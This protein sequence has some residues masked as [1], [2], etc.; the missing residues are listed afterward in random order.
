MRRFLMLATASVVTCCYS[1]TPIGAGVFGNNCNL[2]DT[3]GPNVNAGGHLDEFWW[4]PT[5]GNTNLIAESRVQVVRYGGIQV[6]RDFQLDGSPTNSSSN[7]SKSVA[8][9]VRKVKI[10]RADGIEPMLTLPL[11]TTGVFT[12]FD[13]VAN[14]IWPL[15]RE[16][17]SALVAASVLPVRYWVYSN[18]P[19]DGGGLHGYDGV[20]AAKMIHRFTK[21]FHD[22][23]VAHWNSTWGA[24]KF[25]GPELYAY[26]NYP[27][28]TNKVDSL[29][30]QLT[31]F[32][33]PFNNNSN[34]AIYSILPYVDI[35]SFHIYPTN[36]QSM[37]TA[38]DP[39]GNFMQGTRSNVVNYLR[40]GGVFQN[41][42]PVSSLETNLTQ[43]NSRLATYNSANNKSIKAAITEA[44]LCHIH[45]I[46]G[47]SGVAEA[48]DTSVTG[49][50]AN[51]FIGGQWWAELMAVCMDKNTDLNFWS[52]L[53]GTSGSNPPYKN[54]IGFLYGN[55][56]V[57]GAK[58]PSF[59]HFKML[60]DNF[61]GTFW[62]GTYNHNSVSPSPTY[63][64]NGIKVFAAAQPAG[65]KVI[66][67]NHNASDYSYRVNLDTAGSTPGRVT[68]NLPSGMFSGYTMTKRMHNM[69]SL[70]DYHSTTLLTFDC[71]GQLMS[72]YE[73]TEEDAE[74]GQ[75]PHLKQI[76]KIYTEPETINCDHSG[77]SGAIPASTVYVNDTVY[78]TDDLII[79]NG[80]TLGFTNCLVVIAPGKKIIGQN[81][82]NLTIKNTG[83]IGC[84]QQQWGGISMAGNWN[85]S[86]FL[87]IDSSYIIN[88]DN[89]VYT[90][91]L[92]LVNIKQ[93]LFVNG[94]TAIKMEYGKEFYIERNL[95]GYY[96]RGIVTN[97]SPTNHTRRI[98]MN[99]LYDMNEAVSFTSDNHNQLDIN[100][101][102]FWFR[103]AGIKLEITTL[104]NQGSTGVS[105]GNN[106]INTMQAE[107][108][109]YI[110]N[111]GT[112]FTYYYGA[113]E[114]AEF[115][116]P[117]A[118]SG[119]VTIA[120][121]ASDPLCVYGFYTDCPDW[122]FVGVS[123][124][125][126]ERRQMLIY[127][128]PST[129]D[130]TLRHSEANGDYTLN[131]YDVTGRVIDTR[132]VN[133]ESGEVHFNVATRGLY[134]VTLQNV[135]GRLTQKILVE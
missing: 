93:T 1:Q 56:A 75:G 28:G 11:D 25:V 121:A 33:S 74:K 79:P 51:S 30:D 135:G 125:G 67:I 39:T 57:R 130:F 129:G 113:S 91:H 123:E 53:E 64:N 12:R 36:D 42:N 78:V 40:S 62:W 68:I 69:D 131:I 29:I 10:M 87:T 85:A 94:Q 65:F 35:F 34:P 55:S 84:D 86:E 41:N 80:R 3:V 6:E 122:T 4:R 101:N 105:A 16:V 98:S 81:R 111:T 132:T 46:N 24:V 102:E 22:S 118:V 95:L 19:E 127:P 60:A 8:D 104:K 13:S 134:I 90:D 71:H 50:S 61:W 43:L 97:N 120:Q 108:T 106:F 70:L 37:T 66:I 20:N 59:H 96:Q 54:D 52:S 49:T 112:G 73:Y 23:I 103:D 100:C 76:G 26:D 128:N 124:N 117:T 109:D 18:E 32:W 82:T 119:P 5:G 83:I 115:A 133:F 47:V 77:I 45:D 99:R 48:A 107:P 9:Y 126:I 21:A 58:K 116:Y 63:A 27:H 88:A 72:R 114:A 17:N 92:P 89:P 15:V 110:K 38:N 14:K 44:N 7:F 31:G 2:T